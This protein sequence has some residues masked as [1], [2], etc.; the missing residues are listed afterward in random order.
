MIPIIYN[1]FEK[2]VN[3]KHTNVKWN[4]SQLYPTESK[5]KVIAMANELMSVKDNVAFK[6]FFLK[7]K[8]CSS[9]A[10]DTKNKQEK[11]RQ[12]FKDYI[13]ENGKMDTSR[14]KEF[15]NAILALKNDTKAQYEK[16][17]LI[18]AF[19]EQDKELKEFAASLSNKS[20]SGA[21]ATKDE[22]DISKPEDDKQ[23]SSI[24]R[25]VE[26]ESQ[27]M[28]PIIFN[29]FSK[30]VEITQKHLKAY[31]SK[32]YPKQ[33]NERLVGMVTELMNNEDN[34]R[35]KTFS[36]R[37]K[38]CSSYIPDTKN[39]QKKLR[40]IFKDYFN[41]HN[42]MDVS[43]YK[44]FVNAIL[45][46]ENDPNSLYE[47]FNLILAFFEQEKYLVKFVAS[48]SSRSIS[49]AKATEDEE[50]EDDENEE[51]KISEKHN[52]KPKGTNNIGIFNNKEESKGGYPGIGRMSK[53]TQNVFGKFKQE[54]EEV[55]DF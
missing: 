55:E 7:V 19:Y 10:S 23:P 36:Y 35:I 6:M 28:I 29:R 3:I 22:E 14:D 52:D 20:L 8:E 31:L 38:E 44:E 34:I 43:T 17:D 18:V 47:N 53:E 48:F 39:K 37:V 49:G 30:S 41:Q 32:Y 11:L 25:E 12:I 33:S 13:N 27:K 45:A 2:Q 24:I 9:Y 54:V 42:G 40:Q 1:K 21:K 51:R 16:F 15:V 26:K 50:D 46:L 4:L 5:E